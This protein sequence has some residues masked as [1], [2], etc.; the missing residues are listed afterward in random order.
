MSYY[1]EKGIVAADAGGSTDLSGE[2]AGTGDIFF[3]DSVNGNDSNAGTNR[4]APKATLASAVAAATANNGDII[5]FE[6]GHAETSA[7]ALTIS[8]AGL[9]L[10]GLGGSSTKPSFTVT[11]AVN[12]LEITGAGVEIHNFRFPIGTTLANTARIDI[13][14]A[15][16]RIVNCEF[17]CGAEDLETITIADAGDD[18]EIN[19]CT[20]TVSADGPDA[21]IEIESATALR[22]KVI[23]CTFDGGLFDFDNGAIHSAVAHTDFLYRGNTLKNKASIKHTALATGQAVGTVAGMGSRVDI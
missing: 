15:G 1:F 16:V 19:G 21:G 13:G 8:T 23:G 3:V 5:I 14:A 20:F 18:C 11:G 4:N 22:L 2:L 10:L 7:T 17:F 9:R 6:A 12:L